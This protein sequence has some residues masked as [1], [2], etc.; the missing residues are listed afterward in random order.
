MPKTFQNRQLQPGGVIK[1][2]YGLINQN[3][4]EINADLAELYGKDN[5]VNSRITSH[6]TGISEKHAADS[7]VFNPTVEIPEENN[8]IES[9]PSVG[10]VLIAKTGMN[11]RSEPN[12][13][14]QFLLS[15]GKQVVVT[16]DAVEKNGY[17]WLPV[18][19]AG[20]I[21][22]KSIHSDNTFFDEI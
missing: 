11:F 13:N 9:I 6:A 22:Y 14:V 17:V 12:G 20:Y 8:S 10:K 7:I 16:G 4:A 19:Y 21:A 2:T 18:N 1:D 3:S 15:T 5:S